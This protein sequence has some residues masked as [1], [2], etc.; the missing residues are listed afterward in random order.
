MTKKKLM[1][2]VSEI[3]KS[4]HFEWIAQ[5][6]AEKYDLKFILIGKRDTHLSS[7]LKTNAIPFFEF[8]YQG[9]K[10][11]PS[12]WIQVLK[13][14]LKERPEI[15]HTHLWIANLVG[16]T[17]AWVA[18]IP[19][20]I[21]TRHHA[22]VHYDEHPSGRKWDRLCNRLATHIIAISKSVREILVDR[23]GA[24]PSKVHVIPH[25]FD[26]PYFENVE[27]GRVESIRER[28]AFQQQKPVVGVIARYME[29]KGI[30]YIVPAFQKLKSQYPQAHLVLAN[31]HGSYG[32][33]LQPMLTKQLPK[34]SYTEIR[35]ENDLAALYKVF[36]V[37]VHAPIDPHSE[38]FGQT[39]IEP[40]IAGIPCVFTL[41]GIAREMAENGKN[42]GVVS[43][44]NSDE[45][46]AAM[47]KI[48]EDKP[49]RENLIRQGRETAKQYSIENYL[50]R[51]Q[52]LY[53]TNE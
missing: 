16:L 32:E 41:S 53:D 31:A 49:F 28:Y 17:T 3:D 50:T 19:R 42:A 44:K 11:L 35:F 23:D 43:F 48:I 15:L 24:N 1:Y 18:R 40:L 30:Q 47:V 39:Y 13:T 38:A 45:I 27:P 10:S 14:L 29:W 36:D 22:M 6:L 8:E 25:G 20:R 12:I 34:D 46:Y 7:F 51:L 2:V 21:Y 4:L 26:L 33:V 37:F 52:H 5:P 9:G